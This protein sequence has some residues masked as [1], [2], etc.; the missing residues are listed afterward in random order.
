MAVDYLLWHSYVEGR[1]T[2]LAEPLRL[3]AG[4][5]AELARLSER[6]ARLLERSVERVLADP[7]LL[8]LYG[9]PPPLR[10]LV[11]ADR[12]RPAAT[13]ARYDA[14]RTP[15]GWRFAEFNADVPGGIHEAAALNDLV[16]GDPSRFRVVPLLTEALCRDRANPTVAV[17]YASGFGED[18]EQCQFLRRAWNRAG[19]PAIL[20]NPENLVFDGRRV[21]VFGERVDAVYRFF[22]GE[23]MPLVDNL[24]AIE[25]ATRAGAVRMANGFASLVAQSKKTMALWHERPELLSTDELD[26][27]RAHVPRS[28]FFRASEIPRY[29]RER[30]RLVV[31]RQFGRVGE[32][33]LMGV[34]CGDDEWAE[35]LAWPASEPGEWIVQERFENLPLDAGGERLHGC[36]G[37]Y[38][39]DGRFAGL[40]NRF[41]ADGFI[42]YDAFVGAVVEDHRELPGPVRKD[43]PRG[44]PI[45]VRPSEPRSRKL[46]RAGLVGLTLAAL[47]CGE[48]PEGAATPETSELFKFHRSA[49][50]SL[51]GE[52]W[53]QYLGATA[54]HGAWAPAA[55]S[56]WRP[57]YKPTL[58]A[59]V[60]IVRSAAAPVHSPGT[61]AAELSA[62]SLAG[63]IDLRNTAVLVDLPGEESVAWAS[64]LARSG[65]QPVL[66]VNNWPHPKGVLRLE[67]ALGALLYYAEASASARPPES[68]PPVFVLEGQR[69]APKGLDP[70][71]NRFDN[72]F[73]HAHG[74]FPPADVLKAR[75]IQGVVYVNP[76]GVTAGSEE[77]DLVGYFAGLAGAGLNFVYARPSG[78]AVLHAA[79]QP[80]RRST[81][82]EP[83]EAARYAASSPSSGVY[84]R[85]YWHYHRYHS[86]TG[87]WS[88]SSGAWG[89]GP[90]GG[91]GS[92]GFSS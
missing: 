79:A 28:E 25:A 44:R 32:E 23:W 26:L 68:A 33:V 31:K 11:L 21:S 85:P 9:F 41:S 57:Y 90:S 12:A 34:H 51:S 20:C 82:F 18:L 72:R 54:L 81:I 52:S 78:E 46:A 30:E 69:L 14:F 65:F 16:G 47:G 49:T 5:L 29:L 37:P 40:Y 92:S 58:A 19:I 38:V 7:A 80:V 3:P 6:F 27:V 36:F 15:G 67:R 2:P 64:V 4:E 86:S 62:A 60:S 73:F 56:P 43:E 88:R 91:G 59:S 8:D 61:P 39:V 75:G 22:P 17:C 76:R 42:T 71:S 74:D 1:L 10:R 83:A 66:A 84:H 89:G 45:E 13:L 53:K 55:K 63:S 70:A 50:D 24:E 87:F 48:P 35:W 77:D